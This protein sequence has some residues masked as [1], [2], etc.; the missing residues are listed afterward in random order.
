MKRFLLIGDSITE[1]GT[2]TMT[3]GWASLLTSAYRRK[4]DV[5]V[6]GFSGY[7]TRWIDTL[8]D[9]E[10]A[11][12]GATAV[13]AGTTD[14]AK[15]TADYGF[16]GPAAK[17]AAA[18]YAKTGTK[19]TLGTGT[20]ADSALLPLFAK[21]TVAS[22]MYDLATIFLGANDAALGYQHVP[23]AEYSARLRSIITKLQG[24]PYHV[25][26]VVI[27]A[28]PPYDCARYIAYRNFPMSIR[29]DL[30][31]A[32]YARA[33]M[34][35]ASALAASGV[36]G[37]DLNNLMRSRAAADFAAGVAWTK[38]ACP[39]SA[40][41]APDAAAETAAAIYGGGDMQRDLESI[42]VTPQYKATFVAV[43]PESAKAMQPCPQQQA[44][45]NGFDP[46]L[47]APD[48]ALEAA[49]VAHGEAWRCGMS[50]GLHFGVGANILTFQLLKEAI[51]AA[52]PEIAPTGPTELPMFLPAAVF[53]E[54]CPPPPRPPVGATRE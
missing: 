9:G 28:P 17:A 13:G 48:A 26:R 54:N 3:C 22:P 42:G 10:A 24:A 8:L 38:F 23:I 14:D 36:V 4:A 40:A 51:V 37:L 44:S 27:I 11:S 20:A 33:A 30:R 46:S 12:D 16:I 53:F 43:V 32:R 7:N 25:P 34:E 29:T 50:D 45:S 52:W 47:D 5:V 15:A 18:A 49:L 2:D 39:P 41:P 1:Q 35:V 31:T 19:V 6:R 21:P